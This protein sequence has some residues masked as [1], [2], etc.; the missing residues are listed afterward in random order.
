MNAVSF[1]LTKADEKELVFPTRMLG[2]HK[3]ILG[4]TGSGKTATAKKH[5]EQLFAYPNARVAVIDPTGAWWGM[6]YEPDGASA[7]PY[8]FFVMGGEH[9]DR[10]LKVDM[11]GSIGRIVARSQISIILD[12]SLM[13]EAGQ[14]RFT[15]DFLA[16]VYEDNRRPLHLIVDEADIF[17]P[18]RA[19]ASRECREALLRVMQRGRIRKI[20]VSLITQ[21]MSI[22]DKTALSQANAMAILRFT[23]A[24]DRKTVAH[25]L[26]GFPDE[27]K[28]NQALRSLPTLAPGECWTCVLQLG[29]L[30]RHQVPMIDTFDSSPTFTEFDEFNHDSTILAPLPDLDLAELDNLLSTNT[31]PPEVEEESD[32]VRR[33]RAAYEEQGALLKERDAQIAE[34]I[35]AGSDQPVPSLHSSD[36]LDLDNMLLASV[37]ARAKIGRALPVETLLGLA[38]EEPRAVAQF[39]LMRLLIKNQLT[40]RDGL[41]WPTVETLRESEIANA[42]F[43]Q[44]INIAFEGAAQP[45]TLMTSAEE[46]LHT[47]LSKAARR[48]DLHV[49]PQV[50]MAAFI[51]VDPLAAPDEAA[52]ARHAFAGRHVDFI[53]CTGD[54][55]IKA[56]VELDDATH[57]AAT[58]ASRDAIAAAAGI[59]T[60]RMV[61]APRTPISLLQKCLDAAIAGRPALIEHAALRRITLPK[62]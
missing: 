11:G 6:R 16:A 32:D 37:V 42:D 25:L 51:D 4:S 2:A 45:K 33:L 28:L 39:S 52:R 36:R 49:L 23:S 9:S 31:L 15:A 55:E 57:N 35:A 54:L 56:I 47:V 34:M 53:V 26:D 19:Q 50:A 18:Q 46:K 27:Q 7:S 24:Q 22:I 8:K 59:P 20:A 48:L 21:R 44:G 3:A 40:I 14:R 61:H 43:E 5:V 29:L 41:V 58:D 12:L 10:P 62:D 13:D 60:I 30:R 1:N 38:V 17:A